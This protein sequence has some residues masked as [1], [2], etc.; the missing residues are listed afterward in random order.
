MNIEQRTDPT[1]PRA[2]GR[3]DQAIAELADAIL[4]IATIQALALGGKAY[5]LDGEDKTICIDFPLETVIVRIW[6]E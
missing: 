6:R 3:I 1:P 2:V 5:A 4:G